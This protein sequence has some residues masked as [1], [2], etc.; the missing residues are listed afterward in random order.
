MHWK[1]EN[2]FLAAQSACNVKIA[3]DLKEGQITS[4]QR[5]KIQQ[6]S[7]AE[8]EWKHLF[9]HVY[10]ADLTATDEERAKCDLK[11]L[12]GKF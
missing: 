3:T 9:V 12:E 11:W 2:Y 6:V 7:L 10:Y 4:N 1:L 5:Q 8:T